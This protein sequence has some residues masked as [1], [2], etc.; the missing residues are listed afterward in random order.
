[1]TNDK[2]F[3]MDFAKIYSLLVAKAEKRDVQRMKSPK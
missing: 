3:N 2:V 1:M